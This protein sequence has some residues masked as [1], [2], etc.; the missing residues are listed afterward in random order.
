MLGREI[1]SEEYLDAAKNGNE[2]IVAAYIAA[3]LDNDSALNVEDKNGETALSLSCRARQGDVCYTL[4][5]AGVTARNMAALAQESEKT[6]SSI[7]ACFL[8][9]YH[10]GLQLI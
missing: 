6:L 10:E 1:T 8:K 2:A 7:D 5:Q 4:I 3:N 9:K